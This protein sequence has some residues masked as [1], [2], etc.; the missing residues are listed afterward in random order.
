MPVIGFLS[1][2]SPGGSGGVVAAFR[3][4]LGDAGFVEGQN[5]VVS[6]RWAEGRYDRL[7]TLAAA[8]VDQR[9]AAILALGGS[10]SALA[11]KAATSVILTHSSTMARRSQGC[12][13]RQL[14]LRVRGWGAAES[15]MQC[16][17]V[18]V[19]DS[20]QPRSRSSVD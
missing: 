6:F 19:T 2:R 17:I 12:R 14:C 1:S 5:V 7:P 3:Q 15:L 4:G 16:V 8:L 18:A 9:V 11:A 13:R 10:S 20:H